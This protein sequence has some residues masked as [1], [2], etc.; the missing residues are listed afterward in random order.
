MPFNALF[1]YRGKQRISLCK[2][3]QEKPR[4][5]DESLYTKCIV[6][7]TVGARSSLARMALNY[8]SNKIEKKRKPTISHIHSISRYYSWGSQINKNCIHF[9]VL[10][11]IYIP[12]LIGVYQL[13]HCCYHNTNILYPTRTPNWIGVSVDASRQHLFS[14]LALCL[15]L[16]QL[17][18][19]D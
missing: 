19:E 2:I 5:N 9:V 7:A 16:T 4:S 11:G 17:S 3:S 18:D 13:S 14:A 15:V 10:M 6:R 8:G 1:G 12:T